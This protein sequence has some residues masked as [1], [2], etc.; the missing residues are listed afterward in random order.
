MKQIKF[1]EIVNAVIGLTEA[2]SGLTADCEAALCRAIKKETDQNAAFAL[3]TLKQNSAV[4]K[5]EGLAVCQDTGMAVFFVRLGQEVHIT[6]GLLMGAINEGVRQGYKKRGYRNSV[7]HP[8]T[9]K[10][11]GDN[12]PAI[13][14]LELTEGDKLQIDFLPKGFG[15]E[16]MS[17]LYM[18][19]PSKGEEGVKACIVDAVKAAG[20][21]PCP[22]VVVGVGIGG[23]ADKACEL[24]KHALLRDIGTP[25]ADARLAE[26]EAECLG[27]IN[28]LNIG[29]QGFGG[30]NT[31]YA[32][33]IETFP[34]HI[35]GLP[36]A[37]N[38]QCNCMRKSR[39][40]L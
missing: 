30:T 26:T 19:T 21:N 9:R 33:H 20:A 23:T 17:K 2:C 5:A 39:A 8:L 6:G 25:N 40:V 29:A 32:V 22:P 10:N 28:A 27:R 15:S 3:Q 14:H 38:I 34:T 12:T 37:V 7:L 13:I 31:A 36:V 35:A 18:L 1:E 11:T 16:N 24:A 4:S